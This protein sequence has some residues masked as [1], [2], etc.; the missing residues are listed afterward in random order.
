[1]NKISLNGEW[2]GTGIAPNGETLHFSAAVPGCVH[3]DMLKIGKIPNPFWC[4]NSKACAW[5]ENLDWVYEREFEYIDSID[6]ASEDVFITFC[7]LDTYCDI[8]LNDIKI[9]NHRIIKER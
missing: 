8:I 9:I 7:G 3:T 4:D 1:M 6:I 5:I 2:K